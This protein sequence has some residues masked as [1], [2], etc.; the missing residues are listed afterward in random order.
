VGRFGLGREGRTVPIAAD[1][2]KIVLH[3]GCGVPNPNKLHPDFR[4]PDWREL[5]LDIDRRVKPDIV[6]TIVDMSN[7]PSDSVDAVW[8]SHN[9]EHIHAHEVPLALQGFLRVL[10][11]GGVAVIATPDLQ[12]AAQQI[13]RGNLEGGVLS[14]ELGDI[15][16]L[17]IVYGHR[18]SIRQGND[19]MTHRTGFTAKTLAAK[20]RE[21]GFGR[22]DVERRGFELRARALRPTG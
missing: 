6:G 15:S 20:L 7:V 12:W 1:G 9:I 8:S 18:E 14:S 5:R 21:A 17:D 2:R 11:P 19:F 13:A 3:V 4:G 10:R 16:P 22:V